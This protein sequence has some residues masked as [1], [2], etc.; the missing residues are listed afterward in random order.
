MNPKRSTVRRRPVTALI[1]DDEA[2]RRALMRQGLLAHGVT[3]EEASTLEE[4]IS[5]LARF[6][7]EMVVCD[8]V[9]CDP[10]DAANPA[11][12]GY[13][14]AC[15]ALALSDG[16]VIQASSL[17]RWVH[18]GAVL[19][20]WRVDEVADVV[21]GSSGIPSHRSA[22][23]GC[24][25]SALEWAATAAPEQRPAAAT[26]LAELPIVRELEDSLGL[27]DRLTVLEKAAEGFE[28]WDA[29]VMAM[30]RVLF[31]CAG[32]AP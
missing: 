21:H 24:P 16:V 9:L 18:A 4:A 30:R 7:Y 3:S 28:D 31:P 25:W 12:R 20:N 22:D 1:V 6:P 11:L 17:R 23:G 29:A 10:P 15:A 2:D 19:T 13:L 5:R 27:R 8:M 32:D 26:S 14:A